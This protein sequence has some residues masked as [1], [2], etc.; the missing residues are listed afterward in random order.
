MKALQRMWVIFIYL[1][2]RIHIWDL[3]NWYSRYSWL[4]YSVGYV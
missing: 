4:T 2:V 3:W 1:V